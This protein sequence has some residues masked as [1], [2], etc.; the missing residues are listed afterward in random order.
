MTSYIANAST[1]MG[2]RRRRSSGRSTKMSWKS[3]ASPSSS[4]IGSRSSTASCPARIKGV[5]EAETGA[6]E[7]CNRVLETTD[8]ADWVAHHMVIAILRDEE[9]HRRLFEGYL[10]E[11]PAEGVPTAP[12]PPA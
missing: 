1:R 7:H 11:Y 10:R 3:S 12:R 5:I 6:I 9:R 4:P 8:G 2:Y